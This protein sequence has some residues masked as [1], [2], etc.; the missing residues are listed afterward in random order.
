MGSS[1]NTFLSLFYLITRLGHHCLRLKGSCGKRSQLTA[2]PVFSYQ[3]RGCCIL[4]RVS[5]WQIM[6]CIFGLPY[7]NKIWLEQKVFSHFTFF[8]EGKTLQVYKLNWFSPEQRNYRC[9][10]ALKANPPITFLSILLFNRHTSSCTGNGYKL[11][12]AEL[13]SINIA[14]GDTGMDRAQVAGRECQ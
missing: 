10:N 5:L 12:G 1:L 4:Y 8:T 2:G 3:N 11:W 14:P 9:E 7:K 6:I 13:S